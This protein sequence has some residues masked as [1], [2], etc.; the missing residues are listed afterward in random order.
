MVK[1]GKFI[2]PL[3]FVVLDMKVDEDV[4]IIL[5]ISFLSTTISLV[6]NHGSKIILRVRSREIIFGVNQNVKSS[7]ASNYEVLFMD[8]MDKTMPNDAKV[9]Q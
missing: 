9:V 2:F 4:S 8:G 5:G 1:T 3:E 6:D 7:Q